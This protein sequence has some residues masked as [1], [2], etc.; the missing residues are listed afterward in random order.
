ME[1]INERKKLEKREEF[2]EKELQRIKSLKMKLEKLESKKITKTTNHWK[3][4]N[5]QSKQMGENI[6]SF[7]ST[8]IEHIN[9]LKKGFVS[10][11]AY[12]SELHSNCNQINQSLVYIRSFD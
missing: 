6:K 7:L 11:Q 3:I 4:T 9:K 5:D 1:Q 2:N 8:Q 12:E 10:L